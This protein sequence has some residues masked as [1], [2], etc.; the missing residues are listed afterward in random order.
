MLRGPLWR[1][2]GGAAA[3]LLGFSLPASA[4]L[5]DNVSSVEADR[6]RMNASLKV[7]QQDAYSIHE[8]QDPGGT[9]VDE[10]VSP[11]GKV[12]AVSWRGQFPPQMQQILGTYFQQY[13]AALKAQWRPGQPRTYGHP[14]VD[15]QQPGLVVQ[16]GGPVRAQFGRAYIP[17]QL[18]KGVNVNQI[19]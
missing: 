8:I 16:T 1:L 4:S 5:G 15:L 3:L 6:A 14:P 19:R 11:E 2:I 18:P 17:D 9:V 13:A 10:Y 12:F 7:M